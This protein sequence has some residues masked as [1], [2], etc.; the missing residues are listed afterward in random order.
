[1][2]WLLTALALLIERRFGYPDMVLRRISHPVVWMGAL[3]AWL[4]TRLNRPEHSG[5]QRRL[6]GVVGLAVLLVA[7]LLPAL[8]LHVLLRQ[9]PFGWVI[10]AVLA[11]AMLAQKEL[12]RAVEAVMFAL[13]RSLDAGREAVSRI[14]GRDPNQLDQAGVCR[15]AIETLAESTSDG[16]VAPAFF[17]FLFGLPGAALYKAIN[18]ADSMIGH[19]TLRYRDYGWAAAKLDDLVNLVPAR[20]TA[21]L[22][23]VA[24]FFVPRAS[25]SGAL[26]AARRDAQKHES[27]NAG[28]PESA[29][30]GALGFALGGP[31]SY[32][33]EVVDLPHMGAGR[34]ELGPADVFSALRLYEA[35]LWVALGVA[36]AVGAV[37]AA[38]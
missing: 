12:G 14:V 38:G 21:G 37:L 18:T 5:G 30:A 17:L 23:V 11:T 20:L 24:C 15:A 36:L 6:A 4:E 16:V 13:T 27:P 26:K 25:P 33:G 32:D 7:T 1:M 10:E 22:V 28:W 2:S 35:T 31:R 9:V 34:T 3:I 29:F 8:A 19:R